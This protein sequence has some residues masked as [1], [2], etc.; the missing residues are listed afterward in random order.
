MY[1]KLP[2]CSHCLFGTAQSKLFAAAPLSEGAIK[3]R[4]ALAAAEALTG[5]AIQAVYS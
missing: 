5:S 3:R 4:C 1:G 2:L